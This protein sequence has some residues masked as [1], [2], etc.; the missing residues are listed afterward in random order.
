MDLALEDLSLLM[1]PSRAMQLATHLTKLHRAVVPDGTLAT[2]WEQQLNA[3]VG[4]SVPDEVLERYVNS[5]F[6]SACGARRASLG[7]EDVGPPPSPSYLHPSVSAWLRGASRP[8]QWAFYEDLSLLTEAVRAGQDIQGML[9]QANED[10]IGL[11]DGPVRGM[12]VTRCARLLLL[13]G[14]GLHTASPA[15]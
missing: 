12:L 14:E 9:S 1:A 13:S 8:V 4:P 15:A 10:L 3:L 5:R 2:E 6:A 11:A 7:P